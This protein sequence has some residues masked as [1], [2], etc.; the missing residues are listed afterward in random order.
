MKPKLS[1]FSLLSAVL[2]AA[3]LLLTMT[4]F[5]VR[6][7]EQ[8][9]LYT[10]GKPSAPKD[11]PG[12]YWKA[13]WPIQKVMKFDRAIRIFEGTFEETYTGDG[14]NV[15][16]MAYVCWRVNDPLVF[17]RETR[18]DHAKAEGFLKDLVRNYKNG[19]IG[20]HPLNHLVSTKLDEIQFAKIEEE[21][22][23]PVRQEAA[24][25]GIDV[26]DLGIKRLAL[27][28]KTTEVVFQ[29]MVKEREKMADAYL[30]EGERSAKEIRSKAKLL[31]DQDLMEALAQAKRIR[32]EA[33]AMAAGSY[34]AMRENP[35]LALFLRKIEA[36]KNIAKDENTTFILTTDTEPFT[37]LEKGA[38][39]SPKPEPKGKSD[40]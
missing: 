22:S 18:G 36:L 10:F 21:I 23:E 38:S 15:I 31:A 39:A 27:P 26:V 1:L 24:R 25:F 32:G 33:D 35:E 19:V 6:E 7:N 40:D 4:T 14:K 13:P 34:L 12:L 3:G 37:L 16:L 29:R 30:A 8:A 9:V 28:E 2:V 17:M 11:A 5:T 20:K